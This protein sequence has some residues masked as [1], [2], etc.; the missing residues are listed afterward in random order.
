MSRRAALGLG[1]GVAGLAAASA[2]AGTGGASGG[3]QVDVVVVGAGFAGLTAARRLRAAGHSVVVIEA[4]D[5]V[6]GRTMP[7]KIAGEVVDLGGQWVGPGQSRLL[8]LAKEF[9][10]AT[11]PQSTA[12]RSVV[13]VAGRRVSYAGDTPDLGPLALA[14]LAMVIGKIEALVAKTPASRPWQAPDAE[15]LDAQTV[16]SWILANAKS[17]SVRSILRLMNRSL[18]C[19]ETGEVSM[20]ALLN[21]A[22]SADGFTHMISTRGGAQEAMLHGGVWQLAARMARE[23]GPAVV[24]NA[25]V[26]AIHQDET[27][28]TIAA[29]ERQWRGRHALVT[30][31]P[32]LAGR[33]H[34]QPPLPALRDGLTQRMPLGSVIKVH[35]AFAR[36]FWR[37]QGLNGQVLSDRTEFGPWFDHSPPDGSIGGLVG[38]FAGRPAQRWADRS[39]E[40]RR[41]QVLKDIAVY[42]G[43]A[44][45]SPTDYLEQVWTGAPWHRGGYIIAPG[46]GVL[47]AFGSALRQPVGRIHWAGAECADVWAGYIDGAIGS[48]EQ[49]AEDIGGRLGSP[50]NVSTM[51]FNH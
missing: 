26:T 21:Y 35:V 32:T 44:A 43:D 23:L 31:P 12:G 22:S 17:S 9:G 33:I 8:A 50:L 46:P 29:G 38:F 45:L 15:A 10:V 6:G 18:F 27:G 5:R 16:E 41:E 1:A 34:Y 47:T 39:P 20:L 3:P 48:G 49:S 37:D 4:D 19:A 36:P 30:A 13:D 40:A 51:N 11:Y 2:R 24:L 25:P 14:E 42:L 28:V 7:G